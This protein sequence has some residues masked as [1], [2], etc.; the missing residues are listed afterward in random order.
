MKFNYFVIF[1]KHNPY[2]YQEYFNNL[3]MPTAFGH[4]STAA[5]IL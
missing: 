2:M 4:V 3:R 1:L 5:G